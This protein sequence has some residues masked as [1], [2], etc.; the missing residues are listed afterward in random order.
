MTLTLLTPI[1]LLITSILVM[2]N[3]LA[4][5]RMG[6]ARSAIHLASVLC[7]AFFG[8][9]LSV[10]TVAA[11]KAPLLNMIRNWDKINLDA[12]GSFAD[13]ILTLAGM[14]ISAVIF[15]PMFILVLMLSR[16]IIS[17]IYKNKAQRRE[18]ESDEYLS[19][20][21]SFF[22]KNDKPIGALIGVLAGVFTAMAIMSPVTG[23]LRSAS[24]LIDLG[25]SKF[26]SDDNKTM[27]NLVLEVEDYSNDFSV[28]LL[29][30]CGGKTF[31]DVATTAFCGGELTNLSSELRTVEKMQLDNIKLTFDNKKGFSEESKARV[32]EIISLAEES[33]IARMLLAVAMRDMSIAWLNGNS[34]MGSTRP[35]ASSNSVIN[36]LGDELL[37]VLATSTEKTVCKDLKT[38][39]TIYDILA[40][41]WTSLESGDYQKIM[42]AMLVGN[43]TDLIRDALELNPHMLPVEATIDDITMQIIADEVSDYSKFT[44]EN[45][46]VLIEKIA[47]VLTDSSLKNSNARKH[48][49]STEI[50]EAFAAYGVYTTSTITDK[51]ADMLISGV[52]SQ[53][54][55]VSKDAVREYFD[56]YAQKYV[57]GT[58]E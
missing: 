51:V 12:T 30:A 21:A 16:V 4:G 50:S 22:E 10:L 17:A 31:F 24:Y 49:V 3:C 41:N 11:F 40:Q 15:V 36:K 20:N 5:Y 44:Y 42:D 14:L 7:S 37:K 1:I 9:L 47:D 57:G 19:E 29:N 48:V 56:L 27:L 45:R 55:V 35:A 52:Y 2:V 38:M 25:E 32:N 23:S 18:G 53:N 28:V 26:K 46:E 58:A 8:A 6:L 13:V 43:M 33:P 34:Y 39:M 54:G